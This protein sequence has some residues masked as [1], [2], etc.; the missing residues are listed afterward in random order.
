M[1]AEI[2][3]LLAILGAG[4]ST[5]TAQNIPSHEQTALAI[6]PVTVNVVTH[7]LNS[8]AM[9]ASA[10]ASQLRIRADVLEDDVYDAIASSNRVQ[11]DT[12]SGDF[13]VNEN[14]ATALAKSNVLTGRFERTAQ[15]YL[16]MKSLKENASEDLK[17]ELASFRTN[18]FVK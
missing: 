6:N 4:S 11:V 2:N 1:K 13:V 3:I 12:P 5:A 15:D 10:D 8:G 18:P 7:L 9:Y 16:L 17:V 14:F